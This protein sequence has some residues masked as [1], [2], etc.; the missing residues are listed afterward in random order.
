MHKESSMS[1]HIQ[2]KY[3]SKDKRTRRTPDHP[4]VRATFRPLA[5]IVASLVA[6][7]REAR[8]L[9]VGCG[10][11]FLQRSLEE[12]FGSVVGI[13]SSRAMLAVNPCKETCC[14][15]S[16]ELPFPDKSF[17]VS[18]ASHLLHH[19]SEK[20]RIKTLQEMQRVSRYAV[21]SF[22]PNRN[23]PFVFLFAMMQKEER[24]GLHFSRS[25]MR[26]L[27]QEAG[28]THSEAYLFGWIVPNKAPLWWIPIGD[29]LNKS[30]FRVLGFDICTVG[31][32]A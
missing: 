2:E 14:G 17:D 29:L 12:R 24:M 3:W 20:E 21:V 28:L 18:V 15:F 22:E 26:R 6:N 4:V 23:N 31:R 25:Y 19:V 8:V 13:D 27:F 9:D 30:P 5:Q 10:N 1:D 7:P 16:T 32:L 11:G